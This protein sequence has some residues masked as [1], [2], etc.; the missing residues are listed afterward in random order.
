MKF[1]KNIILISY[2]FK[3]IK[4]LDNPFDYLNNGERGTE[5]SLKPILDLISE[6]K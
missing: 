5:I 1:L 3:Q 6:N 2:M 4:D